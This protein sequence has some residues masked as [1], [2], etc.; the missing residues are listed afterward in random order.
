MSK[1]PPNGARPT[2]TPPSGD[3]SSSNSSRALNEKHTA[4]TRHDS[5]ISKN[6]EG[7][8]ILKETD[9]EDKLGFQYPNSKKWLIITVIFLVQTSMNFNASVYGNAVAPLIDKF[10][11]S[12]QTARLGQMAFL[13]AYA[14]GCEL[15][16]PWSEEL[17]RKK[18]LQW[19][20]GL[21]NLWQIPCALASM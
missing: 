9:C 19:S 20:L 17:G 7:K 10:G 12:A 2:E 8:F 4:R 15:W 18:V 14:F 1:P 16:A 11:I 21:V 13:V 6:S 5:D 3:N